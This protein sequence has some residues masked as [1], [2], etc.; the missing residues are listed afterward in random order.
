ME[1]NFYLKKIVKISTYF[2]PE[3]KRECENAEYFAG[4]SRNID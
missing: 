4:F 2:Q 3:L 1:P